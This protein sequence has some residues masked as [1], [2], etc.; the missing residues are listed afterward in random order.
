MAI[1]H[2]HP[3]KLGI[4]WLIDL[5]LFL[6]LSLFISPDRSEGQALVII[7]WLILSIPVFIVTWK[8][9]SGRELE[10]QLKKNDISP[11]VK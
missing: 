8:W 10:E 9:A 3:I 4:V 7:I 11:P 6:S 2:W 5:A 1:R